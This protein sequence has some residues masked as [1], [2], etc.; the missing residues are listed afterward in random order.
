MKYKQPYNIMENLEENTAEKYTEKNIDLDE[1]AK[2]YAEKIRQS[3]VRLKTEESDP[4]LKNINP[5]ELN[6]SDLIIFDK[7][8][9]GTL[10]EYEL[11]NHRKSMDSYFKS[12]VENKG[13]NFDIYTDSRSNLLAMV[14][15]RL[16]SQIFDKK[17]L[18]REKRQGKTA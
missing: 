3:I 8:Q 10:S 12:Q 9:K 14:S 5:S 2:N 18:E 1:L 17:L 11:N 7:L 4:H 13:K 16:I 15:N 6:H